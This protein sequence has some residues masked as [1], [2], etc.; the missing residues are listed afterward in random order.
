MREEEDKRSAHEISH[1]VAGKLSEHGVLSAM[2]GLIRTGGSVG[3]RCTETLCRFVCCEHFAFEQALGR[4][5]ALTAMIQLA[6]DMPCG[7]V[8]TADLAST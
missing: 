3:L 8:S 6:D 2:A 5:D 1:F 4:S 7:T